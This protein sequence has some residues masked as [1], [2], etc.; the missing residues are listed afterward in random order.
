MLWYVAWY[1]F[2]VQHAHLASPCISWWLHYSALFSP[3][4]SVW[5]SHLTLS[6]SAIGWRGE[7]S[8]ERDHYWWCNKNQ[9]PQR[10]PT[11]QCNEYYFPVT[12]YGLQDCVTHCH[13]STASTMRFFFSF[14]FPFLWNFTL[15]FAEGRQCEG[16]G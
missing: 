5:L 12:I 13:L 14:L 9:R 16:K 7:G 10:K 15:L 8:E 11:T 2:L 1:L 4:F 6:C 3:A